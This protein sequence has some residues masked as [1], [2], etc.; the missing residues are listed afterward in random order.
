MKCLAS[1]CGLA[2][3]LFELESQANCAGHF[4]ALCTVFGCKVF[5]I[6]ERHEV[7]LGQLQRKKVKIEQ[8]TLQS[9]HETFFSCI[10]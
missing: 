5:R 9:L 1:C 2:V 7:F 8:I 6:V 4:D 3:M 10:K